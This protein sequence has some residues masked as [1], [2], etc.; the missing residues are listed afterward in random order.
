[1]KNYGSHVGPSE[2]IITNKKIRIKKQYRN[3]LKT[4]N[5]AV[6]QKFQSQIKP[7]LPPSTMK[8][9]PPTFETPHHEFKPLCQEEINYTQNAHLNLNKFQGFLN[10]KKAIKKRSE[11]IVKKTIYMDEV[12]SRDNVS[13][14]SQNFLEKSLSLRKN[15]RK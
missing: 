1:M 9:Q 6:Y 4:K 12:D 8:K 15:I 10:S 7:P 13:R 3:L 14:D 5:Q 11:I 2:K